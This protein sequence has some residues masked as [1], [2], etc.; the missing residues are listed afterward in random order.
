MNEWLIVILV[1]VLVLGASQLPIQ[2]FIHISKDGNR[3]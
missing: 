2:L 1:V 3:K